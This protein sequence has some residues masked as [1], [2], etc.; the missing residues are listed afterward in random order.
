[1]TSA[2]SEIKSD[3]KRIIGVWSTAIRQLI[4]FKDTIETFHVSVRHV[5]DNLNWINLGERGSDAEKAGIAAFLHKDVLTALIQNF[6]DLDIAVVKEMLVFKPKP[7]SRSSVIRND[8]MDCTI[9]S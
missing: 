3:T 5:T 9:L 2:T 1:M 8:D 6:P 7:V 4:R